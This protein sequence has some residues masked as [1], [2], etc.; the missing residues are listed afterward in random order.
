MKI[1]FVGDHKPT[2]K[3]DV[4][5]LDILSINTCFNAQDF[6]VLILVPFTLWPYEFIRWIHFS[7]IHFLASHDLD[8][9]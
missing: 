6:R 9:I 2:Q 5:V 1:L 7:N 4:K 8:D 3:L